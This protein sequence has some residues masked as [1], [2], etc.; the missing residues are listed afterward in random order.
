MAALSP[1]LNPIES[2]WTILILSWE[3]MQIKNKI[4]WSQILKEYWISC[5]VNL[6][7][8]IGDCLREIIDAW[9]LNKREQDAK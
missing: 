2:D 3:E 5:A 1:N 6:S 9:N 8:I 4:L 7:S